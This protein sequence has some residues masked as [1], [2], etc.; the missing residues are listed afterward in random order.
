MHQGSTM[1]KERLLDKTKKYLTTVG[2]AIEAAVAAAPGSD[3]AGLSAKVW[4]VCDLPGLFPGI[5]NV[6][7]ALESVIQRNISN[8]RS[9]IKSFVEP[10]AS[11]RS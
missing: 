11:L 10:V 9:F 4:Q 1:T 8:R 7:D 5:H 3:P 6:L 2:A